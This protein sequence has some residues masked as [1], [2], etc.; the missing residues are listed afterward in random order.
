MTIIDDDIAPPAEEPAKAARA[1]K[2]AVGGPAADLY[3]ALKF[4]SMAQKKQGSPVIT[5]SFMANGYLAATDGVL[6]IA[7]PIAENLYACPHT[8]LL[9]SALSK[10]S[11]AMSITHVSD[12]AISIKSGAL[13]FMVPCCHPNEVPI[14]PPDNQWGVI[15]QRIQHAFAAVAGLAVAGAQSAVHA[16]VLLQAN[17]A[18]ANNGGALLEYWHG[19]DLPPGL[20]LPKA[21]AVAVAKTSKPLKGIGYSSSS[22][23]FWYED[24]SFIKSALYSEKYPE[25]QQVFDTSLQLYQVPDEFFKAVKIVAAMNKE[26]RVYFSNGFIMSSDDDTTA[27]TYQMNGLPDGMAFSA[28]YLLKLESAFKYAAFTDSKVQCQ[29]DNVRGV[30][31]AL[32]TS[33]TQPS[34]Q[35]KDVRI[36]S[37]LSPEQ[38]P[39]WDEYDDDIPF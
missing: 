21:S 31:M 34:R 19:I 35:P 22:V 18:V 17:S 25:Y 27:S 32:D 14:S 36:N 1:K 13:T 9:M 29:G 39:N 15:D 12:E 16:S 10:C 11:E 7:T 23:T 37:G 8:F 2:V 28:A 30:C 33:K 4:V 26:G 6:T 5:H 20:M 24:G 3:K 38:S